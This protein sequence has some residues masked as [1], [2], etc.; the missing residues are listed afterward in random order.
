MRKSLNRLN[1]TANLFN[2]GVDKLHAAGVSGSSLEQ[3]E[4]KNR[5]DSKNCATINKITPDQKPNVTVVEP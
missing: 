1:L 5:N 2:F 3:I 4:T